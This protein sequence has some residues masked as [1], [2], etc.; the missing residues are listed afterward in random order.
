M[1]DDEGTRETVSQALQIKGFADFRAFSARPSLLTECLNEIR[2]RQ[3]DL[4]LFGLNETDDGS[5]DSLDRIRGSYS[6]PTLVVTRGFDEKVRDRVLKLGSEYIPW[7]DVGSLGLDLKIET[8]LA[9]HHVE[10]LIDDNDRRMQ[11]LFVNILTVM[12]KILESKD[13]YTRFHSHSVA[14]WSRMLG[15]K[16]G[17]S[18]EELLRL[19]LAAVFHDFGKIG[20]PE[21]IL[22]KPVRLTEEEFTV[23]MQHP[24]IA[25]DL[26]SS[27]DL[28]ADL[29]PAITHHHE[30]WDGTGYPK[31]LAGEDIPLWARIIGIAD[32]Y[33]TMASRRTYKEPMTPEQVMNEFSR[34]RGTQFDP[35]L[36]DFM[37]EILE[38]K[39]KSGQLF[40]SS[41]EST[42][43]TPATGDEKK[44]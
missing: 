37:L 35:E 1:E 26:L 4:V 3:P 14:M 11:R 22:N 36:V 12:V 25:R 43:M 17:L 30:R 19:G 8:M 41:T 10:N 40:T 2:P 24:L 6:G 13:P 38:E 34:N 23:M 29:L 27:I 39:K 44:T 42:R 32:A 31:K 7:D 15:R 20:I 5:W 9:V 33:D 16:K 18:E 21:D 28:L